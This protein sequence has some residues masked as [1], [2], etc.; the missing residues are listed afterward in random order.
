MYLLYVVSNDV[1]AA[2]GRIISRFES[3]S[4]G[5]GAVGGGERVG[6]WVGDQKV[7]CHEF[8]LT[9]NNFVAPV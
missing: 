3:S 4:L 5:T 7:L 8:V 6:T 1:E 2:K 9:R